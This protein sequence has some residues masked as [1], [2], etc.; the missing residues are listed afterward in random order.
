MSEGV[1]SVAGKPTL[2]IPEGGIPLYQKPELLSKEAHGALG[3][4]TPAHPFEFARQLTTIPLVAAEISS[5]QKNYPVIFSDPEH[6]APVAVV[7]VLKDR[8][9]FVDANGDWE[10]LHYIPSYLRR[11]PFAFAAGQ[12]DQLAVVIDRSSNCISENPEQPFFDGDGLTQRT[13]AMVDFCGQYEAERR[14]TQ[15]FS[16]KLKEL[17]LLTLQE[18]V[19]AGQGADEQKKQLA[20]YYAIDVGKLGELEPELLAEMHKNG[21]LSFIFAH[22]F[23]LENWKR[24]L[25]RREML[26]RAEQTG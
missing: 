22:L 18:V 21:F 2:E 1:Q 5:A 12:N 13:Q 8:N 25:D 20:T 14:R 3:F 4:V 10:P 7:S 17:E 9:M 19:P 23:S 6:A 11:H 24:L 15:E 16:K 26:I